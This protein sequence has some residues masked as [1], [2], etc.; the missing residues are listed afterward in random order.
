MSEEPN[1]EVDPTLHALM[2]DAFGPPGDAPASENRLER[3]LETMAAFSEPEASPPLRWLHES[4]YDGN[5]DAG[6]SE[7]RRCFTCHAPSPKSSCAKCGVAGY[8]GREC[9]MADWGK[10]GMWGGHKQQ[11]A[12]YKS[13]GRSQLLE[14]SQCHTVVEKLLA[15][16]RLTLCPFALGNGSG[17]GISGAPRGFV[18]AQVGCSLAQLALPAP[19][20]CAG[21]RLPPGERAVLLHFVTLAEFDA[22]IAD[23]DPRFAAARTSLA[24]AVESHDDQQEVVVLARTAC[25]YVAVLGQP[26]VPEWRIARTLA[27]EFEGKPELEVQLDHE[28]TA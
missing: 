28:D 15:Q 12:A 13:L 1:P 23:I 6:L 19:R 10:R 4:A 20:D 9:Q 3:G 5:A 14:A 26:L 24:D 2:Q 8:C 18:F 22:D 11:C 27:T 17:S 25:G 7:T 21:Q 16:L